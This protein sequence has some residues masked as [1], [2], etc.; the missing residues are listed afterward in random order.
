M[1][2]LAYKKKY[3]RVLEENEKLKSRYETM[4]E[5]NEKLK[6]LYKEFMKFQALYEDLKKITGRLEAENKMLRNR[7]AHDGG[8]H[9]KPSSDTISAKINKKN[10]NDSRK[11]SGK[12][13]GKQEGSQGATSKP[14]PTESEEYTPEACPDCGSTEMI[15]TREEKRTVTEVP[16]KT[17]STTTR[18]TMRICKCGNC[19]REEIR[20]ETGLPEHGEYG[21]NAIMQVI[22]NYILRMTNR[23]NAEK[24]KR[25]GIH[26]SSGTVHNVTKTAGLALGEATQRIIRT[27]L[28][29]SILHIDETQLKLNGKPVWVWIFADPVT[30]ASAYVIRNS[31]GLKVLQE[32]LG[33]WD[34]IIVCD[35]WKPYARYRIQRCWAHIMREMRDLKGMYRDSPEARNALRTL[36]RIYRDAL[37]I[38]ASTPK[39]RRKRMHDRLVRR[40]RNLARTYADDPVIGR[41]MGKLDRASGDLFQ[42]VLD[43]RIPP[44]NN[45]AERGLREIVVHRKIRGS[46]RSL[47]TMQWLGNL[48]TCVTT[49]KA[50]KKDYLVEIAKHV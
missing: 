25:D 35:G 24:M 18:H 17:E 43:P 6:S 23:M 50:M 42:F 7:N 11:P 48:F 8:P 21:I 33:D 28:A 10:L 32:I 46:I 1:C 40:T 26:M 16:K 2:K 15:V 44:T 3:E 30:G 19:G 12:K 36:S 49:W 13:Q 4:L 31:R 14:K 34:G 29:C 9:S 5:E 45:M 47:E 27:L 20:P 41:F 38:P 37:H 22:E 39:R